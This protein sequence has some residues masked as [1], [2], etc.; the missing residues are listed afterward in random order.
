MSSP[1]QIPPPPIFGHLGKEEKIGRNGIISLVDIFDEF[2]FSGDRNSNSVVQNKSNDRK[3]SNK[4]KQDNDDDDF[5]DDDSLDADGYEE[6]EDGKKRKRPRG[7]Q[8]NMT[9]EQKI[10]RR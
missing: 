7:V 4:S 2:L 10:E 8:R 6:G 3:D 5:D 9:E 1:A